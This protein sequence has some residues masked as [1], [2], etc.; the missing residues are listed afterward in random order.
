MKIWDAIREMRRLS[1]ENTP[2]SFSFMSYSMTK[3]RS[4]GVVFVRKARLLKRE[5][6]VY[7]QY[8][9]EME[10]YLNLETGEA[11]HF[12]Q[13]LLMSFEGEKITV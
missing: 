1:K 4:D 9:E 10:R 8:A 7:N 3:G 6:G 13:P 12:W 5:S 11:R 2:F